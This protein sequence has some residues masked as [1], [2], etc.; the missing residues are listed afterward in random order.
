MG[1]L[2][3]DDALAGLE[4]IAEATRLRLIALLAHGELTVTELTAILGQSQPRISRHLK[5]LADAGVLERN[6]EGAFAYFRLGDGP[7]AD[8]ARR[9]LA[10]LDPQDAVTAVD[11][12]R[13]GEVRRQRA[14]QAEAY[15]ASVARDWDELR[16][17]HIGEPRVEAAI[18]A[19]VGEGRI[20]A[21]LDIGT[22]TGR[23]LELFAPR[24][25]RAVGVD[26]SAAMLAVARANL[27]RAGVRHVQLRQA[28]LNALPLER[29]GF[30]LVLCHQVLHFLDDPGRAIKEAARVLAPGGRLLIVDFAPHEA[31][32]LRTEHA[33]RRLGFARDEVLAHFAEA[34]LEAAGFETLQREGEAGDGLTVALWCGK[35]RRIRGDMIESFREVA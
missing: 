25:A 31:D 22:G 13:L 5:L 11:R 15:F 32:F 34:G 26:Q 7:A 18:A 29:D 33:H 20:N 1:R 17:L 14:V 4:A 9:I 3:F 23:M 27:E 12:D 10:G 35:D 21:L 19:L 6:R 24:A 8:L 2:E 28:D 16:R 30:D